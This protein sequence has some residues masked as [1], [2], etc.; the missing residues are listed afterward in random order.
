MTCKHFLPA[1]LL[2]LAGVCAAADMGNTG[3]LSDETAE[4]TEVLTAADIPARIEEAEVGEWVLYRLA[5]GARSK[6]TV[7]EKW[8][9]FGEIHLIIRNEF[10][11]PKSRRKTVTEEKITV[12]EAV[13]DLRSLGPDD[14][15]TRS[16][17]LVQGKK[18]PSIVVHSYEDGE[19]VRQ[20]YLS[21]LIPVHGLV[22]GVN[23]QSKNRN[24]LTVVDFGFSEDYE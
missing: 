7:V 1:L 12:S 10:Q 14:L 8:R 18:I 20:S 5:D 23:P 6:L 21:D 15:I 9:D 24:A 11:K 13:R 3:D 17:V 16:T 2:F 4:E 19:L 22:R